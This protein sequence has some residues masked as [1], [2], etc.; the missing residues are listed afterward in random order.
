MAD[1]NFGGNSSNAGNFGNLTPKARQILLLAN[2]EAER[3]NH[4]EIGP[5]HGQSQV[6]ALGSPGGRVSCCRGHRQAHTH[7]QKPAA[8]FSAAADSNSPVLEQTERGSSRESQGRPPWA[9]SLHVWNLGL[10]SCLI[11]LG[12]QGSYCLEF[13]PSLIPPSCPRHL[14]CHLE[15][16]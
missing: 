5:E 6:C 8:S 12:A 15:V 11:F 1:P 13:I 2:K 16:L 9:C 14:L 10:R 4:S 3:L 7:K